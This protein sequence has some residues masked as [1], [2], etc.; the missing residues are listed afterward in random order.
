MSNNLHIIGKKVILFPVE[1]VDIPGFAE[2][3]RK[4][5]RGYFNRYSMHKM[6]QEEAEKFAFT[7]MAL[8]QIVAFTI[9]TKEGKASRK[10]GYIYITDV[11][12]VKNHG[13][14]VVGALDINFLKGLSKQLRKDK[15]TYSE[16][17]LNTLINWVFEKL[18]HVNRIQSDVVG[19]N[20][21]SL[22]LMERCGLKREG[23]LRNYL[24]LDDR[25]EDMVVFSIL[26]SEWED[27]K[28]K[29]KSVN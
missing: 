4:D 13:I 3:H 14:S 19:S 22:A 11:Q 24:K 16:D 15:Y 10:A 23:V 17:A 18:P 27:V 26:K 9:V 28:V 7:A 5:T 6:T 29:Q 21:L 20:K 8:G 12:D 1:Q 25:Y 2:I